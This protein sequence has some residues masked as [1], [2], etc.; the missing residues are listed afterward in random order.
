MPF[1][2]ESLLALLAAPAI[3]SFMGVLVRRLPRGRPVV[4]SRS[5]CEQCGRVLRAAELLPLASFAWQRGRCAG[6]GAAIGWFHPAIEL[7]ALAVAGLM[8]LVAGGDSLSLW[9][10]CVLGWTCLTLALIDLWH[11]RLPD[12]LT[13][14]LLLAGLAVCA[15]RTPEQLGW[16]ALAAA[17]GWLGFRTVALLY[18]RLRGIDGLGQGDAKLLAAAGAWV[19][20]APLPEV[21]GGAALL[22]LLGVLGEAGW[23]RRAPGRERRVPFGPGLAAATFGVWLLTS[24]P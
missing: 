24:A 12:V 7:A 13:L 9:A 4:A 20:L 15:L 11:Q 17:L 14:P 2:P 23:R 5:A 3:G 21:F 1:F 22:T 6:C 19:G 8:V 10:G 18:R 16:H